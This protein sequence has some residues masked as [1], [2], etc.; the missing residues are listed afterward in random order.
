MEQEEFSKSGCLIGIIAIL[1]GLLSIRIIDI[2]FDDAN[3]DIRKNA[4]YIAI[5]SVIIFI[6]AIGK[7]IHNELDSKICYSQ[8]ENYECQCKKNRK[9]T[10]YKIRCN[11]IGFLNSNSFL[12]I[13]FVL[14]CFGNFKIYEHILWWANISFGFVALE[15]FLIMYFPSICLAFNRKYFFLFPIICFIISLIIGLLN[16]FQVIDNYFIIESLHRY[17]LSGEKAIMIF[18]AKL[19]VGL[20]YFIW[21][22]IQII[23]MKRLS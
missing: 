13:Y 16:L 3:I 14:F 22:P 11:A 12:V 9:G 17:E 5:V 7:M 18:K 6:I 4:I 19:C 8:D 23:N 21:L 20:N 1:F 15:A 10:F 2:I